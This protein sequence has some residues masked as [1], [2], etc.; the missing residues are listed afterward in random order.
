MVP[1][2]DLECMNWTLPIAV[3][4][5][6]NNEYYEVLKTSESCDVI[7]E[8]LKEISKYKGTKFFAHNAAGYDNKFLLDSLTKH[9]QTV[10]F[11]AGLGGLKWVETNISF[12]DSY[13]ILGRSLAAC[14]EAFEVPRK[15]EWNHSETVNIWEMNSKLDSFRAYMKRDVIALSMVLEAFSRQLLDLFGVVPSLTMSLT[16]VKA[17]S[18]DF[19]P[20]EQIY[21][22]EEYESF[23]RQ[24]TYGGRNEVYKRYGENIYFY[25]V[26]RMFMSCY[27]TPIPIGK[28]GWCRPNIDKGVLAEAAVYVPEWMH[29]GPLPYRHKRHLLYP[30]GK[31]QGWWDMHLLRFAALLGCDIKILRQLDGAEAPILN[32]FGKMVGKLGEISNAEMA[33]IWKIFGLRLTGKF[34]QHRLRTEIKHISKIKDQ[35][36]YYPIDPSELYQEKTVYQDGNKSPYIKP[37]VNMRIRSE[38]SVRHLKLLLKAEDPYYCDTDSIYT[39]FKQE[40]GTIPGTLRQID[41][42]SKGWFIGSK[43]YGYINQNGI[44]KQKTAGF[45]DFHLTEHDFQ[46]LIDG[47]EVPGTF[48]TMGNWR[49]VLKGKGVERLS[50]S[51]T[52][53]DRPINNRIM[54]GINTRPIK[55]PE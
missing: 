53:S 36:G 51:H 26:K 23:I 14:C 39:T 42:A 8:F 18:R 30:V 2:F 28:L 17:F 16:A 32:D 1:V 10:E 7:W 3:G 52:F 40:E 33:K 22:N 41:F 35:T 9:G 20:V 29:I 44:M 49:E 6:V 13:L 25:D 4:Y 48:T 5:I 38:A 34:G 27:D 46:K 55:L 24:A 11:K 50:H 21:T 47:K 37:A 12:E 15:L 31:F 45:H 43:F 19:F 54:D